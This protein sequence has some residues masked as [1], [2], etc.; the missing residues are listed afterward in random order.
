LGFIDFLSFDKQIMTDNQ[1]KLQE[2][3]ELRRANELGY[4]EHQKYVREIIDNP[5]HRAK[6]INDAI[7]SVRKIDEEI[8]ED[9]KSLLSDKELISTAGEEV[10]ELCKQFRD[11]KVYPRDM[12]T[13][14]QYARKNN[15]KYDLIRNM[16]V[17][18]GIVAAFIAAQKAGVGN[19]AVSVDQATALGGVVGAATL[20]YEEIRGALSRERIKSFF[21]TVKKGVCSRAKRI[22][23]EIPVI[24]EVIKERGDAAKFFFKD[25]ASALCTRI[26]ATRTVAAAKKYLENKKP[27]P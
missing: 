13:D 4:L 6:Q 19:G 21:S 23:K 20:S 24:C 5:Q 10:D 2:Y 7:I 12:M 17:F 27:K 11:L 14:L 15:K 26:S 22:E 25:K 9:L 8:D 18:F 16:G 1:K 3:R